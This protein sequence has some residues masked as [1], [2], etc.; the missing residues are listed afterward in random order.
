M[1]TYG[2]VRLNDNARPRTTT[3]RTRIVLGSLQLGV[4]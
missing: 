3:A 2:V 4:V 1:L